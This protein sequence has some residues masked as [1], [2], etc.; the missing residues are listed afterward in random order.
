MIDLLDFS[1]QD[2]SQLGKPYG[3]YLLAE[4][5][6]GSL[7][8]TRAQ[9]FAKSFELKLKQYLKGSSNRPASFLQVLT[10]L[11]VLPSYNT[12]KLKVRWLLTFTLLEI[13]R[14]I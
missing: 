10:G 13:N 12:G 6:L 1:I 2:L 8:M 5:S 9:L 4:V 7:K 11:A 14:L 3:P